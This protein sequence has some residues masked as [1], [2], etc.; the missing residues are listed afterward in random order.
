ML[1]ITCSETTKKRATSL[2]LPAVP[3]AGKKYVDLLIDDLIH[4]EVAQHAGYSHLGPQS[5]QPWPVG[6]RYLMIA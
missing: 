3:A 5:Y 1:Q 4:S 2:S 6:G